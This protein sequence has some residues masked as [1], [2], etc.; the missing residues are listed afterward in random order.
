MKAIVCTNYGSPENVLFTEVAKP[1]PKSDEVLVKLK[2]ASVNDFDWSY[3]T[4]KPFIY[5][6]MF[7]LLKPKSKIPGIEY[8][9]IIEEIGSSI[10]EFKVGDEVY[11]D[12]S[13]FGL[14]CMSAYVA[15]NKKAVVLKPKEM[16]FE[17]AAA[18]SHAGM[19]A[20]Q[21]LVDLGKIKDG[22]D[23]LING[24]GGGAGTIA[25]QI[26]KM[27]NC[28]VT[29]VDSAAK[30]ETM[31]SLGFD[32]VID[33]KKQDFTKLGKQ[34]DLVFDAKTTR[35][36]AAISRALKPSGTYVTVGGD[37]FKLLV[38]A[39]RSLFGLKNMKVLAIKQ[40]KDVDELHKLYKNGQLK[41]LIDGPYPLEEAGKALNYF[42][43]GLHIGKI[44][45]KVN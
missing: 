42:G 7:G 23:V 24:A 31:T 8:A 40:N 10:T 21:S 19:L 30:L 27:Y 39:L 1:S 44:I 32:E 25:L 11:G 18:F 34:Y 14:G 20:W 3:V 22:D 28:R 5:R 6:L 13:D 37:L 38:Y 17:E 43:K 45:L 9:G 35:Y 41:L 4:G 2:A 16:S 36:P 12:L 33:Y 29:G 26:A 15:V